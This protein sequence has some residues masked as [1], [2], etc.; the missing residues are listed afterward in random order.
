MT[1][2]ISIL[3]MKGYNA[4]DGVFGL[5]ASPTFMPFALICLITFLISSSDPTAS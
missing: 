5:I 4:L 3:P 2:A 1:R